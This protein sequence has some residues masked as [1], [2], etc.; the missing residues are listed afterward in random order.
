MKSYPIF[1][2]RLFCNNAYTLQIST[3]NHYAPDIKVEKDENG[4]FYYSEKSSVLNPPI[5]IRVLSISPDLYL[6]YKSNDPGYFDGEFI[7][8]K[9]PLLTYSNVHNGI[10]IVGAV[11]NGA[12]NR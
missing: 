4:T 12:K 8:L 2:T 7:S 9:E 5:E 3:T 10:G 6:Y 1:S 11:A